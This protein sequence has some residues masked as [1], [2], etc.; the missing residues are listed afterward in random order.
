MAQPDG[1]VALVTGA[2]KG[3]GLE[4]ARQLS[5][6]GF[7]VLL[8]ARD[9][10]RGRSAAAAVRAPGARIDFEHL[11]VSDDASVQAAARRITEAF[12]K[13]DVLVNNAGVLLEGNFARAGSSNQDVSSPGTTSVDILRRTYATNVFGV[14]AV[15]N[16]MLPLLKRSGRGRIVNVSSKFASLSLADRICHGESRER[17]FN[18]LAYNTSKAALNALTLQYAIELRGTP[19]KVNAV[20]PGHCATDING[21]L[22]DRHPSEAAKIVVSVATLPDD[23][24]TGTFVSEDGRRAW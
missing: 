13:L 18:L 14:A 1:G 17:Y 4:V 2:N 15:T 21:H 23:G 3:I 6:L 16:A 11:D 9:A 24:P 8:G 7:H 20:D 19:I 22:G 5:G 12:G 10:E